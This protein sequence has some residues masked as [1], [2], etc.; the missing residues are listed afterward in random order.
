MDTVHRTCVLLIY[1]SIVLATCAFGAE[2]LSRQKR[3]IGGTEISKGHS[4][5]LVSL[6]GKIVTERLFGIIPIRHRH[7]YC[8]GS[9]LND[10]YVLTAAHCF[11]SG[12]DV[13]EWEVRLATVDLKVA[14]ADRFM[15]FLGKTLGKK[16]W[17]IWEID[18]SKIIIHP[19]YNKNDLWYQDIAIVKLEDP[20][21]S[22][23][24]FEH[25]KR[26]QLP[27]GFDFSFPAKGS[28]CHMAGWGCTAAGGGISRY[29]MSVQLP[30][31][32]DTECGYYYNL[33]TMF[34]RLCAGFKSSSNSGGIC[35]GDS[36]GPLVC[37]NY[38]GEWTQVGIASF[39]SKARPEK[40][41]AVFTR[42]SD[43][44]T[45]IKSYTEY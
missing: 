7:V 8:G 11:D 21:P 25:I 26:I 14:L 45:W 40:F 27:D 28:N 44:V 19:G 39:T 29:A 23:P 34:G 6:H 30:I 36:G 1:T 33:R 5:W 17:R 31:L 9:L 4:P 18:V 38:L 16:D 2:T 20:V 15:D 12:R 3:V 37:Q 13:D 22:G 32:D 24:R 41:P 35:P 10:R 43:Y 42:V